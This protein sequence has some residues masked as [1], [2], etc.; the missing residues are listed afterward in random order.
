MSRNKRVGLEQ[1]Q[2]PVQ[3]DCASSLVND[4]SAGGLNRIDFHYQAGSIQSRFESGLLRHNDMKNMISR[5]CCHA[6]LLYLYVG[7]DK[8]RLI[9]GNS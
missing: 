7:I 1:I 8:E 5:L 3:H 2:Q 6:S 9:I 4:C